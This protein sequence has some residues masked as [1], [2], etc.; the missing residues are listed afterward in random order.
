MRCP[1]CDSR[2][3]KKNKFCPECGVEVVWEEKE[4]SRGNRTKTNRVIIVIGILLLIAVIA[5]GVLFAFGGIEGVKNIFSPASVAFS[6]N[7]EAIAAASQ[8]VVK[9]NCY[10]KNGELYAAGSGFAAFEKGV[11]ITNYHVIEDKPER[12][13][14]VTESGKKCDIG[15]A[16]AASVERDIAILYYQPRLVDFDLPLL[17]I[18]SS[19]LLQK[20]EKIVA[21]G[22]PLGLI[23]VVSSGIFSGYNNVEGIT[24]IQFTASISSGSSGGALFNDK[25]EI[26]GITYASYEAGQNLNLAVPVEFVEAL[27]KEKSKHRLMLDDFYDSL[28]PHYTIGYVLENYDSLKDKEFY[29]DC[30]ISS[31]RKI[32]DGYVAFCASSYGHLYD[33]DQTDLDVRFQ[34]DMDGYPENKVL[35]IVAYGTNGYLDLQTK[36]SVTEGSHKNQRSVLCYGVEWSQADKQLYGVTDGRSLGKSLTYL[37]VTE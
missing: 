25:G 14:V 11:I 30:W 19:E 21:I 28:I 13:E 20:G 27:W 1:H 36:H 22:S 2:L 12:I 35:K 23:N 6:D 17:P 10:D 4:A 29:L 8:S 18:S 37:G 26:I 16:I 33:P 5:V 24:D 7:P 3:T 32:S 15:S 9:L 31:Y 34:R